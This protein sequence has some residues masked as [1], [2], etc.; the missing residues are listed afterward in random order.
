MHGVARGRPA[1]LHG[2][3]PDCGGRVG[4]GAA[5]RLCSKRAEE[6]K[7][8]HACSCRKLASR[9]HQPVRAHRGSA[10]HLGRAV[11]ARV[12]RRHQPHD[13]HQSHYY[14]CGRQQ[15]LPP[16][17]GSWV[18]SI[19]GRRHCTVRWLPRHADPPAC[20][21][22]QLAAAA[23]AGG[24]WRRRVRQRHRNRS[25]RNRALA[26]ARSRN[27]PGRPTRD[28]RCSR[29]EGPCSAARGLSSGGAVQLDSDIAAVCAMRGERER[30]AGSVP[31]DL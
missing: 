25:C 9:T 24:G 6:G 5:A 18:L 3:A 10:A 16:G 7:G 1:A 20:A 14:R 17:A 26:A 29:R 30:V 27:W 8:C 4:R 31:G 21:Q 28:A 2:R 15:A 23:S 13:E 11:E 12:R 22:R 19:P